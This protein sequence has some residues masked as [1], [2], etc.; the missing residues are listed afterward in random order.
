MI[1]DQE[2]QLLAGSPTVL[3]KIQGW[4][5]S[6][7]RGDS[8][9]CVNLGTSHHAIGGCL[10]FL[11]RKRAYRWLGPANSTC[12][13]A[14]APDHT[15]LHDLQ[16]RF[17]EWLKDHKLACSTKRFTLASIHRESASDLPLF[18][19]K[20]A[21]SPFLVTW[22]A[23]ITHI[24]AHKMVGS[25]EEATAQLVAACMW[26]LADYFHMLKSHGRFFTEAQAERLSRS[27]HVFLYMYSE[28]AKVDEPN[29]WHIVPKFHQMQHLLLDVLQDKVNPRFFTCFCDE[30]MVG[31]MLLVARAGHALTVVA[32]AVDNYIVGLK[33]RLSGGVQP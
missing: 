10:W 18:K 24:F 26:G 11:V 3:S 6:R 13:P 28:L 25:T 12:L 14:D 9:H 7:V 20:A 8:M 16:I 5:L 4:K 31:Q 2:Y 30:D 19:R 21:Q 1:S 17:K 15:I 22:L 23:E 33:L 32:S 29:S 27:G